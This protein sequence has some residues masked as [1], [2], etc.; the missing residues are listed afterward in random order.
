MFH[1]VSLLSQA[2][3]ARGSCALPS[4]LLR[5]CIQ[6][7]NGMVRGFISESN[8]I[9][10]IYPQIRSFSY[11]SVCNSILDNLKAL[12]YQVSMTNYNIIF[13]DI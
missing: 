2:L 10:L 3:L 9:K 11:L 1:S 13:S 12:P 6:C 8:M 4:V 7:V 5:I